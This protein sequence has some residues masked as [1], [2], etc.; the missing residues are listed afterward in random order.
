MWWKS[1]Y[2]SFS[3][4]NKSNSTEICNVD[5]IIIRNNKIKIVI[6]IEES[7][8]KPTQIL[9]K[10]MATALSKY[11]IHNNDFNEPIE[12]DNEMCFIQILDTSKLKKELSSKPNQWI[13]IR[14]TILN[15]LPI[16]NSKLRYYELFFGDQKDINLEKIQDYINKILQTNE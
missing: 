13:N 11:Y 16:K 4:N 14:D 9:G 15:I 8:V 6:E 1:K 3:F 7:N 5:A 10:M 12:M 2:T